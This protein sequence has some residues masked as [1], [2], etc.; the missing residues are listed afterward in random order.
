M[1]TQSLNA[2]GVG[3]F[4]RGKPQ[5]MER[6]DWL[7]RWVCV[8]YCVAALCTIILPVGALFLR[9]LKNANGAY[10][11]LQNYLTYFGSSALFDSFLNSLLVSLVTAMIVVPMAFAYAYGL[12]RTCMPYKSFFRGV[13]LI[14]LLIPGVLKAIAL[15]YLFG[16][17]GLLREWLFGHPLY[18]PIGIVGAS[19][20]WTFPFAVLIMLTALQHVDQRLYHA[21]AVLKTSAWRTFLHVTWPSCRYG[22]TTAF[23]VVTVSVFTDFGIAKVI[24]G[25]FRVLATDIYKEVVGQ[26]NF[27]MGAVISVMLLIPAVLVFVLERRVASKQVAQFTGRSLPYTPEP[28]GWRD[29]VFLGWCIAV[30]VFIASVLG[31]AQFASLVKFWPYNLSLTFAHYE[32]E[33]E[34]VGWMNFS[35]SLW[36]ATL[37]ASFGTLIVFIGAYVVEKA[38]RDL[39]LRKTLQM[40]MLLPMAIPGLVLGLAYLIFINTPGNPA[41]WLYGGMA[42]LVIST[43][44]HLYSVPHLTCLTALKGLDRE[45]ESVGLSLNTS[46]TRMLTQVTL[47]VCLAAL[48]DVWL[49]IFLCAMTTLSAVI[50]LYSSDTKLASIAVIHIDETGRV[51]SAAAMAMLLVYVCLAVRLAHH[52]IAQKI[53]RKFQPWRTS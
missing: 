36:M 15:V 14:P 45:I 21:A 24:G 31:M 35:N 33:I 48:L 37:A 43:V 49:Y 6:S 41:G 19:V 18:G 38:R 27:E 26:Q 2:A 8:A 40:L 42:I 52:L 53:L 9:S 11:G 29:G 39:G 17:Q 16:N 13:A 25:D 23:L 10:V 46:V 20:I 51:A 4:T 50:F 12:L 32:F 5:I 3:L 34:G 44:T 1:S 47:P 28:S 22:V 7:V 30:T